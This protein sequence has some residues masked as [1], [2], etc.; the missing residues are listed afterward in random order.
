MRSRVSTSLLLVLCALLLLLP[1]SAAAQERTVS[2]QGTATQEVPNDTASL[3]FSVSK[4]RR[5][6]AA[7]S[8]VVSIRLRAVIEAVQG[9][10]GVGPGDVTTG[11]V[12]INKVFRKEKALYRASQ[13][14]TVIL[15]Q[16]ESAGEM[17]TAAVAAGATGT[18]GPNF[19]PG[20][21]DEA[22][23]NTLIAAFDQAK[24]KAAA[25]AARAGAILGPA[26]TIQEGAE[27]L[28]GAPERAAARGPRGTAAPLPPTKPGAS[29][30][31]AT[32][33]VVFALQ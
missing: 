31:T 8:R 9:F 33:R 32:V 11:A 30:V 1:A 12:S 7:A 16:P 5:S 15:H 22:Y 3:R 18:N 27:V 4:E 24:A 20:N 6:R 2:V 28:P 23:N 25:L 10:T 17:I 13:G 29:T 19:F 26:L 21:P 14:V